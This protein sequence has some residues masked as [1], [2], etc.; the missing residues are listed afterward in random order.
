MT[1]LILNTTVKLHWHIY[2]KFCMVQV[3]AGRIGCCESK[4]HERIDSPLWTNWLHDIVW[5]RNATISYMELGCNSE[6]CTSKKFPAMQY[7]HSNS[8]QNIQ[9]VIKWNLS[10]TGQDICYMDGHWQSQ[11]VGHINVCLY[12]TSKLRTPL[13]SAFLTHGP[14]P[15]DHIAYHNTIA[16]NFR[17]HP[18]GY[19]KLQ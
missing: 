16:G 17:A 13:Y 11:M 1:L 5:I 8:I 2:L 19:F 18:I 4:N 6:I 9:I 14:T 12:L 7:Y 15:N 10:I 3:F